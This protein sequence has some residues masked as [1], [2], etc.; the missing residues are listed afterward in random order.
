MHD[1]IKLRSST[2]NIFNY[3]YNLNIQTESKNFSLH[4]RA[5]LKIIVFYIYFEEIIFS[6]FLSTK[7]ICHIHIDYFLA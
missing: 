1:V 4:E 3:L 7:Y 5:P 2:Y 6:L